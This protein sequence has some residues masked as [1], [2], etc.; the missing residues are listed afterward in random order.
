MC[1][2]KPMR[3]LEAG[4]YSALCA[5][6]DETETVDTRLVGAV[7]PGEWLLVFLGAARRRLDAQEAMLIRDALRALALAGNGAETG[8]LFADIEARAPSL[9]P[10]L[11][12]A[13][14]AGR[15]TA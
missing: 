9:P 13:R 14:R 10:H 7:E 12:A 3:V 5:L 4:A 6:D 2:G 15:K 8:G 11:E 1:V